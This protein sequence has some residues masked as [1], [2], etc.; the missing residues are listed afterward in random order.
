M[1]KLKLNA[2]F[3]KETKNEGNIIQMCNFIQQKLCNKLVNKNALETKL[4]C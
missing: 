3:G 2:N 4:K 1:G